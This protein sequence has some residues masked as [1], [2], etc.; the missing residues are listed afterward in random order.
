MTCRIEQVEP[1]TAPGVP[2]NYPGARKLVTE[3]CIKP[4][5]G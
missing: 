5:V 3:D 1:V 4:P 2:Q